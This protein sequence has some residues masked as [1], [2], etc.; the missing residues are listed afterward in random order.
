MLYPKKVLAKFCGNRIRVGNHDKTPPPSNLRSIQVQAPFLCN[1]PRHFSGPTTYRFLDSGAKIPME[2]YS[3]THQFLF[4]SSAF[5][6][7]VHEA[8]WWSSYPSEKYWSIGMTIP[9]I[10]KKKKCSKPPTRKDT[11]NTN[12]LSNLKFSPSFLLRSSFG[13]IGRWPAAS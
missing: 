11:L 10:W 7:N 5:E 13:Q 4:R 2:S 12:G 9:N 1:Q 3:D 6:C 8:G